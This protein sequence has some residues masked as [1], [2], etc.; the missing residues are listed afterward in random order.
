MGIAEQK[1]WSTMQPPMAEGL[2]SESASSK[3]ALAH[4]G[5]GIYVR[6]IY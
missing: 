4:Q 6:G 1:Q 3:Q 5:R 2:L